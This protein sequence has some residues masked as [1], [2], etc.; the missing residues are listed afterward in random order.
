MKVDPQRQEGITCELVRELFDYDADTG[1]L[2][3]RNLSHK[4]SNRIVGTAIRA[5]HDRGYC[6]VTILKRRFYAHRVIWLWMTGSWPTVQVDH[7][8]GR[9]G[10]NR[11]CN[12]RE[13]V[14]H[15]QNENL[16]IREQNKSG[17]PG[18]RRRGNRWEARINARRVAYSLGSFNSL[19]EAIAAREAAKAR[20]HPFQPTQRR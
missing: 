20:L 5:A 13:A 15:E 1:V 12:L 3:W 4:K 18:V 17:W 7:R 19:D 14:P 16:K 2:V 8:N 9:T 11:W 10:D 6:M